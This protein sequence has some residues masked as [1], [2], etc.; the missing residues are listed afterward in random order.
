MALQTLGPGCI[1]IW[2]NL[3]LW[4]FCLN[5]LEWKFPGTLYKK[6]LKIQPNTLLLFFCR[7]VSSK[8]MSHS[9]WEAYQQMNLISKDAGLKLFK[10]RLQFSRQFQETIDLPESVISVCEDLWEVHSSESDSG[11]AGLAA[12]R[13]MVQKSWQHLD[14]VYPKESL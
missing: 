13:L 8:R 6:S 7:R 12:F 10:G 4:V 14:P 3:K 9:N 5:G 2:C 1:P 11:P